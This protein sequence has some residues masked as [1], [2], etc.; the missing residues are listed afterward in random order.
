MD[1]P[2]STPVSKDR[3]GDGAAPS[4]FAL[5]WAMA[6]LG[7]VSFG[8][9]NALLM[10]SAIVT[11]RGWLTEDQF[12]QG[13]ALATISPGG[14]SSN[15]SFE[16]G[17]QIRGPVGGVV[18]YLSMALPGM[19]AIVLLTSWAVANEQNHWVQGLLD[20]AQAGV[21]AMVVMVGY[22]LGRRS[23]TSTLAWVLAVVVFVVVALL[24]VPMVLAVPPA[25]AL[26]YYLVRRG[27]SRADDASA[28]ATS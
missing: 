2:S 13:V 25:V 7:A 17:R 5:G 19:V 12:N 16:V 1:D 18:S 23:L 22:R 20:G 21:V 28:G 24:E 6:R 15:L 27:E 8:G 3:S 9:N 26:G 4:L 11:K 14:N 10:S